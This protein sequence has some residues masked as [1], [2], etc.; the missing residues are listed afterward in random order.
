MAYQYCNGDLLTQDDVDAIVNTV[1]CA[2]T[3]FGMHWRVWK[4]T[5]FAGWA[6]VWLRQKLSR[7]R[8][9][10][11][12]RLHFYSKSRKENRLLTRSNVCQT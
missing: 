5:T 6:M 9:R 8:P 7:R 10:S 11:L 12:R 3:L 1:N 4:V 2:Q